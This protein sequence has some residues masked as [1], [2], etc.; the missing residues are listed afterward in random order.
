MCVRAAAGWKLSWGE[1]VIYEALVFRAELWTCA[2]HLLVRKVWQQA[3][4]FPGRTFASVSRAALQKLGL[5][6]IFECAGWQAFIDCAVPVLP[7]YKLFVK[8]GLEERSV[9]AWRSRLQDPNAGHEVVLLLQNTTVSAG[10]RLL[11][12]DYLDVL[13]DADSWERL[14]IGLVK[15]TSACRLCCNTQVGLSHLLARCIVTKNA[16]DRFIVRTGAYWLLSSPDADWISFVFCPSQALQ[17]LVVSVQF[18]AEIE[19]LLKACV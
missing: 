1:K 15:L 17:R 4:S 12:A 6:E 11:E 13:G 3:Q 7:A 5:P 14:R 16:R 10:L 8:S 2:S 18:A 19:H 9:A